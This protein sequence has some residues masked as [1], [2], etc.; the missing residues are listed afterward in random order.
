MNKTLLALMTQLRA[1][2]NTIKVRIQEENIV[3]NQLILQMDENQ[4]VLENANITP[5]HINPEQEMARLS[6]ILK[7]HDLHATTALQLKEQE[8]CITHLENKLIRLKTEMHLLETYQAREQA[9]KLKETRTKESNAQ[10]AW[11]LTKG[12][13]FHE[14]NAQ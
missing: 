9:K 4:K 5:Y 8:I 14:N 3:K 7:K 13:M 1:Q 2:I 11:A 10:D 12:H 6:F